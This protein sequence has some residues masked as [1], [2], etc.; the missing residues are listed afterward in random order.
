MN[1][2][3]NL[4]KYKVKVIPRKIVDLQNDLEEGGKIIL[5]VLEDQMTN[6]STE[7]I[8]TKHLQTNLV[9]CHN[10]SDWL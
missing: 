7:E 9:I 8:S 1:I 3:Q 6:S 10:H 2:R 5:T 4:E